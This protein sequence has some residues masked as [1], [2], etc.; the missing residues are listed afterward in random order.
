MG[1]GQDGSSVLPVARPRL[2]F[3]RGL[4]DGEWV[5]G[6]FWA[7]PARA[8]ASALC[9][10]WWLRPLV[11]LHVKA[12][13]ASLGLRHTWS[14][15]SSRGAVPGD[16]PVCKAVRPLLVSRLLMPHWLE[17]VQVS[18]ESDRTSTGILG[19]VVRVGSPYKVCHWQ[20][21]V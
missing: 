19:G 2:K 13:H 7:S 14:S 5:G 15:P 9:S 1:R 3:L 16:S 10:G 17:P 11:L 12:P 20:H 6:G 18:V 21:R 4:G 8:A